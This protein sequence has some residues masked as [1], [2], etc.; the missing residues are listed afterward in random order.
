MGRKPFGKAD[1]EAES[2]VF[3]VS[4]VLRG[5][6]VD[7]TQDGRRNGLEVHFSRLDL[8]QVEYFINQ[9]EKMTAALLD[10]RSVFL[11]G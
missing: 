6:F 2:F 10:D 7:K 5:T 9:A 1:Q 8:D 3:C 4:P 11:M